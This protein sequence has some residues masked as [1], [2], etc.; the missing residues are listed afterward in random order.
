[1]GV[2]SLWRLA[3]SGRDPAAIHYE[4]RRPEVPADQRTGAAPQYGSAPLR[5]CGL[6]P[7]IWH[8][9]TPR[10][11]RST[12]SS[13]Y[14]QWLDAPRSKAS[15]PCSRAS[16]PCPRAHRRP[17]RSR[18]TCPRSRGL[19]HTGSPRRWWRRRDPTVH[20]SGARRGSCGG[21]AASKSTPSSAASPP[22]KACGTSPHPPPT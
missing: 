17:A 21:G 9:T 22:P 14:A 5:S 20:G 19:S 7:P 15:I 4:R 11:E 3:A 6:W 18:R 12:S 13:W 10:G 1:L 16:P 8:L 2:A